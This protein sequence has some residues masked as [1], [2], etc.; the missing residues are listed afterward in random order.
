MRPFSRLPSLLPTLPY[1]YM[2]VRWSMWILYLGWTTGRKLLYYSSPSPIRRELRLLTTKRNE[3]SEG[4]GARFTK[5]GFYRSKV[6]YAR[7]EGQ[8]RLEVCGA[9]CATFSLVIILMPSVVGPG[10]KIANKSKQN[11]LCIHSRVQASI[12]PSSRIC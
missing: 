4:K 3:R 2:R 11:E 5:T 1:W 6:G 7:G 12:D 8:Q 10:T 9:G